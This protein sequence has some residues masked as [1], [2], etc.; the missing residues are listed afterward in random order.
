[1]MELIS[2][3]V[4]PECTN[5]ATEPGSRWVL[6]LTARLLMIW[7]EL[8]SRFPLTE[9]AWPLERLK[10]TG[11]GRKRVAPECT[12]I[13]MGPGSSSVLILTERLLVMRQAELS[14]YP[15]TAVAWPLPLTAWCNSLVALES[16]KSVLIC[17]DVWH[18]YPFLSCVPGFGFEWHVMLLHILH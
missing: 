6:I 1:M 16:I 14:H 9:V 11:L 7:L 4:T 2:M 12:T 17:F 5:T 8:V 3:R 15:L 18:L 10:T 13:S